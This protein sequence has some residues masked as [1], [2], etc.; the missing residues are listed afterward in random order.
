METI[1]KKGTQIKDYFTGKAYLNMLIEPKEG[2]DYS[3]GDVLFEKGTRNYWHTHNI[4]Q[5]L[6][7]LEGV[8][9]YQERGK[10]AQLLKKGDVVDIPATVE[11]WHGA[12][13]HSAFEHIAITDS[14]KGVAVKWLAEVTDQ[15]YKQANQEIL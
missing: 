12:T 1:F 8:G 3:V 5:K 6:L 2:I 15:E 13:E 7:C 9:I 14:S 11:H 4:G 10:K